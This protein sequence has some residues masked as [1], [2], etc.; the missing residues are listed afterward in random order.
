[1]VKNHVVIEPANLGRNMCYYWL[2]RCMIKYALLLSWPMTDNIQYYRVGPCYAYAIY[3]IVG[4]AHRIKYVSLW[5]QPTSSH[6]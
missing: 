1:M 6:M 3:D 5:A 2:S 4:W